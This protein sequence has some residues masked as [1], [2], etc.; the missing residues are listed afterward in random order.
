M[1]NSAHCGQTLLVTTSIRVHLRV[2]NY[3]KGFFSFS[4]WVHFLS[5]AIAQKVIICY[6]EHLN[7]PH[8]NY[9]IYVFP[10]SV[11]PS[12]NNEGLA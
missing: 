9:Y 7:L 5:W 11:E 6:L 2:A 4:V 12:G 1:F 8:L 10:V 3:H